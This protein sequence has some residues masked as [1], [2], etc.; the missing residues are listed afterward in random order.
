MKKIG[1]KFAEGLIEIAKEHGFELRVTGE[2]AMPTVTFG[3]DDSNVLL[4]EWVAEMVMRGV[5]LA[6]HHN[7]FMNCAISD[8]DLEHTFK[9][10]HESFEVVRKLHPEMY[11]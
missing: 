1:D 6:N 4:Q 10:A 11:R 2:R 9:A 5:F 7:I 3:D 8:E